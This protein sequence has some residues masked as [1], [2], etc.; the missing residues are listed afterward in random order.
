SC[1]VFLARKRAAAPEA[2]AAPA[3][4]ASARA[5]P[6]AAE[7][8]AGDADPP[9]SSPPPTQQAAA[10]PS[11]S[12][13]RARVAKTYTPSQVAQAL[14][15]VAAIGVRPAAKELGISRATL[16]DWERKVARAAKGEGPSPTTGPDPKS[17]E[18][19][20]DAAILAEWRKQQG[21]GPSQIRNQLRR[22]GT[23]VSV[24]TVR[25]VME[26][27]GYVPP[28]VKRRDHTGE[29]EAV[30][31]NQL[32]HLD[33]LHRHIHRQPV[34]ILALID[35]FSRF[36]PGW[37]IDDAE[38]AD[39]V[40][41]AFEGAVER[42]G[43]PEAVMHDGGSAFWAWKG[44]SRFTRL[45]EEYGVDQIK[46][47]VPSTNGKSEVFNANLQKELIDRVTFADVG[48]LRRRLGPHF[49]WY[50]HH[51][52]HHALGGLLVPADRYY[53]RV[54]EVLSRIEAGG[55]TGDPLD[56]AHRTLDLFRVASQNGKTEIWMMGH[57][58]FSMPG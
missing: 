48:E 52:T 43:K 15:R 46:V 6:P 45:L 40:I 44:A 17:I 56:L 32:W 35:D 7:A 47:D 34:F 22:Q 26:D 41:T 49:H 42:H 57:R 2:T 14:E 25:R 9:P 5:T 50:N 30:R 11:P 37:A 39:A 19:K 18:E 58:V 8:V 20:R 53:G 29:Y 12:T 24:Q 3:L 31:R 1:W 4:E 13:R 38:R 36:V 55:V 54:D 33:F 51:R 23:V 28:K 27:A 16:R 21:L 10:G